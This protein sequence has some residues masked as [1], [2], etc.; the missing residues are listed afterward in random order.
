MSW[1]KELVCADHL[2]LLSVG[3]FSFAHCLMSILTSLAVV[4]DHALLVYLQKKT[5]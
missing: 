1:I 2:I 4:L 3:C 5:D